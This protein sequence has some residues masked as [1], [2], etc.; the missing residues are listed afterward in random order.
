MDAHTKYNSLA[1]VDNGLGGK[2]RGIGHF[3]SYIHI[4]NTTHP[5]KLIMDW[6]EKGKGIGH[7]QSHIHTQITTHSLKS[8][9]GWVEK[10]RGIGH[11]QS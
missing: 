5:L 2:A 1:E 11:L 8:S 4:Q 9:M 6:E 3:Q 7:F 10:G